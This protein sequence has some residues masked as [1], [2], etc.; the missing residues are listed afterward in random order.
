LPQSQLH[1]RLAEGI[2]DPGFEATHLDTLVQYAKQ[3][4][5]WKIGGELS[6]E[7]F[8][9]FHPSCRRSNDDDVRRDR[10]IFLY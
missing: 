3:E 4:G 1:G 9:R 6:N 7:L 8:E 5:S 2:P 10:F